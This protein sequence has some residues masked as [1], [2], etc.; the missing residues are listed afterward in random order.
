MQYEQSGVVSGYKRLAAH[1]SRTC[2]ACLMS[3]GKVYK[4]SEAL[5]EHPNGRCAMVPIVIG[6]PATRWTGGATWLR[7]QDAETQQ[8]I[9]GPGAYGA[10][11]RGD[12]ALSDLVKTTNN[13][14]W[15]ASVTQTPLN[16][17]IHA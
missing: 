1:D 10:W 7:Q 14:T 16:E 15:G 17:L 6:M 3:E 4:T 11:K 2:I 8:S 9:M 12:V 13:D 5:D